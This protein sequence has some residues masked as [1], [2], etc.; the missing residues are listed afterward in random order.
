ML[1]NHLPLRR[2]IG[3]AV[4]SF[5]AV[6]QAQQVCLPSPRLLTMMP[7]GG[8]AG[9]TVEVTVTG[10]NLEDVAT[11]L[12]S[13]P[14]I[15]AKPVMGPDGK[16]LG[17]KFTVTIATDAPVGV[18]DARLLSRLGVSSSR[19]FSVSHVP[20]VTRTA[21]NT[22]L[23][24]AL[25]LKTNSI[26]NATMTK[27]AVDFYTFQGVK[28]KRVAVDCA[29]VGIDSKLRPVVIIGD[30]Q[31]KDLLVN[32]TGGVLD[33]T[34]PADGT[35]TVKVHGL[36]FEGGAEQFYRLAI[37]EVTGTGPAPRQPATATVSS[38]SWPPAT[39]APSPATTEIEAAP[40]GADQVQKVTL[41]LDVAGSFFPAA[42][43]DTYEF[44]AK[45]GEV[46]WVEVA[47]E[48]LGLNTD[49]FVLV[50]R[51]T[52]TGDKETLTDVAELHDIASPMKVSTNGYSYDGPPYDA[53]SPDVLG[54]VEIKEDG[55]YRIQLRDLFGGTRNEPGN[56]YRLMVR[57]AVPDFSLAA[58]AVHMTLRN[59]DRNALS[60]PVAL[61]AG[62]SMAFE[63]V[64][65][66]RDGFD[67]DIELGMENL[68]P[69][70]TASGLKIPAGKV[71]GTLVITASPDAKSGFSLATMHGKA[72]ING[73]SVTRLCRLASMEWPVRDAKQEIPSPRLLADIPVSVTDS[74]KAPVTIAAA[75]DKVWEVTAGGTLKIPLKMEWRDEF[76]AAVLK[77]RAYHTGLG[78][79]KEI[80]IPVKAATHELVLD[81]AAL[82][83]PPGEYAF[84][85]YGSAVSRYRYNPTAVSLA[86]AAQK[87][88]EQD[89][90]AMALNSKRLL[91]EAANAPVDKKASVAA[92]AKEA[93]EKQK[94]AELAMLDAAKRMKT[95][96]T[97]AEPKDTV[98][99]IVSK[100]IR[101]LV[102]PATSTPPP[103]GAVAKK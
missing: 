64:V 31:G 36:T 69:G 10:E 40:S 8:S 76:T 44:A 78:T 68:P 66:R 22:T 54:K 93:A 35:Y 83:T 13:T 91:A 72:V 57:Q 49:P 59:G 56:T 25:A 85:L 92:A 65:V 97:L 48:R 84:A 100:P 4:L 38:M 87:K 11:L 32:R 26:C 81:L 43:V 29:A 89:A 58:W 90:A 37:S 88:A 17:T 61:R 96:T 6:A 23:E 14:G 62:A 2:V 21:P 74:E 53:G 86:K 77:L 98:D 12:F 67:G 19:A 20:E 70:V 15:T 3:L 45:K 80:D 7:M 55:T 5:T 79:I 101:I 103:A 24:T 60:K 99:I 75:E 1:W 27:R 73:A 39:L 95:V 71:Q 102:K 18:Y 82:K 46:W 28:G 41:P 9:S 30:A 34:P 94:Q 52:R 51:V 33:F 42:D 16:P 63:V 50:Q 47:S